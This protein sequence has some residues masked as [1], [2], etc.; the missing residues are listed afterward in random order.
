MPEMRL[1]FLLCT[2]LLSSVSLAHAQPEPVSPGQQV[3]RACANTY[4]SLREFKGGAAVIS[5]SRI[6]MGKGGA[7]TLL[8]SA[9]AEFDFARDTRFHIS[10]HDT[11]HQLFEINSTPQKTI[12]TWQLNGKTREDTPE[13]IEMAVAGFTGVASNAPTT[14]PALLSES[15]WGSPFVVRDEATLKG[16]EMFGGNDCFVVTQSSKVLPETTTFWIDTRSFLLRGMRQE[17]SDWSFPI[18]VPKGKKTPADTVPNPQA[19]ILFSNEMHVFSIDKT[20]PSEEELAA[21]AKLN[22]NLPR[23]EDQPKE[24]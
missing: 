15:G 21:T 23:I 13:D 18:D 14:I 4:K 1:P 12:T 22:P 20:L 19:H 16:R 11:T 2:A 8:Q 3:L 6:G 17:Q 10:G 7:T 5:Q 24:N 9:D